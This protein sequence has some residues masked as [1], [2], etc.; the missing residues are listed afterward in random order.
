MPFHDSIEY[1]THSSGVISSR[2]EHNGPEFMPVAPRRK[3]MTFTF[4]SS[5]ISGNLHDIRYA[6][7]LPN[8]PCRRILVGKPT[9]D[10]LKV[11]S[12]DRVDKDRNSRRNAALQEI[13]GLQCPRTTRIKRYDD[14]IRRRNRLVDDE[15]PSC[16][17][18]NWLPNS[19]NSKIGS[20][21]HCDDDC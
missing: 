10:K 11:L 8:L 18:Q 14:D 1:A 9:A 3:N 21:G 15:R 20:R 6:K 19:G 12:A 17:S 13:R 16:G 2:N 4:G 5:F 7:E